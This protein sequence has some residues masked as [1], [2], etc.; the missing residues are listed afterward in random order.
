MLKCIAIVLLACCLQGTAKAF[1]QVITLTEHHAPLK[2]VFEKIEQQSGYT[3]IY[4]DEWL[5]EATPVTIQANN[6]SLE[7]ALALC[8]K[9]QPFIFEMVGKTIVVKQ[10]DKSSVAH[11]ASVLFPVKGRIVDETGNP[12]AAATVTIKGTNQFTVTND[13]GQFEW[14]NIDRNATLVISSVGY[15]AQ[16]VLVNGRSQMEIRMQP[17]D[18]RLTEVVVTAL[19]IKREEKSLGYAVTKVEGDEIAKTAPNNWLNAL[20][21]KVPGLTLTK[22]GAGPGGSVRLTLRGQNSLDLDKGEPLLVIDG[23]P[24]TSGIVSSGG[25]SYGTTGNTEPPID[26]GNAIS[27]INPEDIESV[28]VLRGPSAAALYGSRAGAGVIIITTKSGVK[29]DK[30][31]GVSVNSNLT[32]DKVLRYPDFQY[33]YG[34]GALGKEAYFSFGTSPDGAS[35]HSGNSYGPKFNGQMYYQYNPATQT[36]DTGRKPWVAAPDYVKGAFRTG[37][38]YTNSIS[39]TGGTERNSIRLSYTNLRNE[40]LVENTGYNRNS[41]ALASTNVVNSK[42]KINTKLN[43]YN[44]TSDN[45]PLAGYSTNTFMYA[46][47]LGIQPNVPFSW[48]RNYWATGKEGV[49]QN[50]RLSTNLDNPYFIL[51]EQLNTMN[52]HRLLGN[53]TTTYDIN[54]KMSFQVRGGIDQ[55]KSFRTFRRPVSTERFVNGNYREQ[56]VSVIE[57][58]IDF[59]YKYDEVLTKNLKFSFSAGGNNMNQ[60][61]E[62]NTANAEQLSYPAL[63]T[64]ANSKDRPLINNSRYKKAVN[65]LYGLLQLNFKDGLYLDL[66]GRNDWSSTLPKGNNSYFYSSASASAVL[67]DLF[68]LSAVPGLSFLK[69]RASLSQVGNDTDPY[70]TKLYYTNSTFGGSYSLPTTLPS[71]NLKPEIITNH[72]LGL[73]IRFLKNRIG[74][75]ITYYSADSKNQILEVPN[76]PATGYNFRMFNAGLINNSG[77]EVALRATPVKT[78]SFSWKTTLNWS[79]NRNTIKELAPGVETIVLSTGPG[80]RAFVQAKVGGRIGDLYGYGFERSPDGQIVYDKKDGAP[81]VDVNAVKY[82]GSTA[83]DWKAGIQNSFTYRSWTFDFLFE[84]QKGGQVY[85]LT[86][87]I[88]AGAGR[89]KETLPG[90]YEGIVGE[91]VQLAEDGKYITNTK[92][93][94]AGDYY[95]KK[96]VRDNMETNLFD[97][98]YIKLREAT[99]AYSLPAKLVKKIKFIQG[100]SLGIYGRDLLLFTSFPGYDPEIATMNGNRIEP[101]FET[102]QFLSSRSYGANFKVSF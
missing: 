40:Y 29:K 3:F 90:R 97:V 49:Q 16:Q 77:W 86:H 83:A 13:N 55:D 38:T 39:L 34:D 11:Q 8:F 46:L 79:A 95:Q 94:A 51:Y 65:S 5:K 25:A 36:T 93:A 18:S 19:G 80:P 101:G 12:L 59:L 56:T 15:T 74:L 23:V 76:D 35:T 57:R 88:L 50:N 22:A 54:K 30:G 75:D 42:I 91:G 14:K 98:S 17:L 62:N 32:F 64:L 99:L 33:E 69:L 4:R 27:E 73:D 10:R 21:G 6:V 9:D 20:S 60:E 87:S 24:A 61:S 43:Y 92:V 48:N 72:E 41:I 66:T 53:I 100:A 96:F 89:L 45:L 58:N 37:K 78:R 63:Y 102:G 71:M 26:Y 84:G 31:I 68:N 47:M 81:V 82:M 52:N 7:A 70:Q 2:R 28:S 85:S 67:T 1:A 44:K